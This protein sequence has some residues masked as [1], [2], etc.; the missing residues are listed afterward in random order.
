MTLVAI[1]LKEVSAGYPLLW[2]SRHCGVSYAEMLAAYEDWVFGVLTFSK[3]SWLMRW[4]IVLN[5]AF[6]ALSREGIL[7]H[8]SITPLR[9]P[10]MS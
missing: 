3:A 7:R 9:W 8:P 2:L 5:E 1:D 6:A 4:V 10:G